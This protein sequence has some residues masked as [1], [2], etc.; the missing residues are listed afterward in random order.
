MAEYDRINWEN[1]PSKDTP[2][3][4]DNLNR[5]DEAIYTVVRELKR[6][7]EL[8][9][10]NADAAS[11]ANSAIATL[12]RMTDGSTT[13]DAE[14]ENGRITYNGVKHATIGDAIRAQINELKNELSEIN[15]V[16]E[17][18]IDE[19][20][21]RLTNAE[22]SLLNK[23]DD[24]NVEEGYLYMSADGEV[25]VGP[26]GPFS[27]GGGGGGDSQS[28]VVPTLVNTS[29]WL[30]KIISTDTSCEI[31]VN[32]SS[33][34]D[35]LSTGPG[36]L[37]V[38]VNDATKLSRTVEQGDLVIEMKD[39]L[40]A[41][42]NTVKI[43]ITNV[44]NN[45]KTVIFTI[46]VMALTLAANIDTSVP[47]EGAIPLA[48]IPTG[49]VSKIIH[50]EMDG[51][52]LPTMT[53]NVSGTQI[54]YTIPAQ[55]HGSHKLRV[56]FEAEIEGQTVLSN[57]LY[58]DLMC[59]E[60]GVNT[61]IIA[62]DY[63]TLTVP[64]YG[65]I[66]INYYVYN[67]A[68]ITA[69][70]LL[71]ADETT[72]STLT[73]D[74]S[75]QTWSY[76][77]LEIGNTVLS[78]ECGK[79]TK[80]WNITVTESDI[81][82]EAETEDLVLYLT[83]EGRSNSEETRS[84]WKF[85]DYAA[86]LTDFGWRIDG[87]QKDNE[88]DV[89]LR[90]TGDA[91]VT[92]PYKPFETDFKATGKTIEVEFAT[93]EVA[94]YSAT[95]LSCMADGIG[96]S[97]TPQTVTFKGA[98]TE[99]ST[100]YKDNEHLRVAITVSKQNEYRL[101][102]IYINGIISGAIQYASG[103]RFSQLSPVGISIGSD[104]SGVDIYNIRIYDN[105]LTD[106]QIVDNWIADTQNVDL[107]LE[108]FSRNQVYDEYGSVMPSTIPS[109]LPYMMIQTNEWPQ[110]KGDKRQATGS[111]TDKITPAKS[112]EFDGC[113]IDRQGTSSSVYYIPNIDMKF[114]NGFNQNGNNAETYALRNGSI[115]FNR[116]V[117]KADVASIESANN[118]VLVMFYN[119]TCPYKTPEMVK[120]SA[121]RWGIEGIP[122]VL[123]FYNTQTQVTR[124][125]GKYNFN[126]P[127]RA[128]GPYGYSGNDQSW[129]W[130]RNNSEN[131]KFQDDDFTSQ[132][133][134][135]LEQKYYPTWYDDFEARFPSDMFRDYAALKEF[136][137]WVKSTDRAAATSKT[138]SSPV[139]YRLDST[140]TLTAYGDD[141]T[142]T[143]VDETADGV[144]TGIKIVTFTADT[145]AYRLSKFRAEFSDYAE[146]ESAVFYYLFT[147]FFLMID[148]RA[149]NMFVGFHGSAISDSNRAMTRKAVFEPYD[150]DTAIGTNNSGVLMF[151]PSL[152]DTDTVS[153]VVVG[154]TDADVFNAQKSVIW[155]N[156]RDGFRPEITSMY[157]SL[158]TTTWS[159]QAISG[160]FTEHQSKWS[161]GIYNEDQRIKH[162]TP[163]TEP[164]TKDESTGQL[165]RTDRYLTMV[166]GSKAE[167]RKWWLRGRFRY[168]DSKTSTGDA[169][170][171]RITLR[172]F[173]GGT[174]T[175]TPAID[176]YVGV[177][178]GGGT[179]V[180]LK[181]TKANTPAE[182]VY[183]Q[184]A[185]EMET[186]IDSGD[187]ISDVGDLSIFYPNELDFSH[188]TIL[189]RLQIG[190]A[191]E[192][193][194]NSHLTTFD[195]QNCALL[196]YLDCR[197][198]PNLGITVNLEGSPRLKEAYFDN[199]AITGVDLVD[200]GALEILHLPGTIT[201]LGLFNLSKLKEFQCD[202]FANVTRLM[203]ANIDSSVVDAVALLRQIP[204]KSLVNIQGLAIEAEDA[205][206]ISALF[207]L[208]DTMTGVSRE[209][210]A[211]GEWIY[212]EYEK[213]QISGTIH[214]S[215]LTGAEIADFNSRYPYIHV[216]ADHTSSQLN[217]YNGSTFI[218]SITVLDGGNGVYDGSTPTKAQDAQ[219]TYSFSGWSR[220]DDNTVDADALI[221]VVADRNVYACFTG[222]LRKYTVTFAR[223]SA[224]G[225]GTLQTISNVTYGTVITAASSYTGSTPT[226]TKGNA[227][228]YPFKEWSP[229]SVRVT[230]NTTITAVFG[231]PI[232]APTAKTADG[233]WGVEWDYSQ[234]SPALTRKGLAASVVSVTPATSNS[235]VGDSP[236]D[237]VMPWAGMKRYNIIDGVIGPSE[238]EVGFNEA[239]YDT[240]V[241][242]P[243][244]YYTAYKDTT[245]QKWLWAISP[246][247]LNGYEKHPGSG[248]YI[249]RFHTSRDSN[250]VFSKSGA[251]PLVNTSQ[252]NFR[253]YSKNKG[254]DWYMLDLATWSALQMLYLIEY[255]NFD[256]QTVLGNGYNVGSLGEVGGT[257]GAQ[258]HTIKASEAHNQYRWVE[259]PFS[260]C[261]DWIDGF[262]G[263][264]S[265]VYVGVSNS[266]FDGTVSKL[267]QA[268]NLK[269]PSSGYIKGYGYSEETAWAFI[270]DTVGG[271]D[272]T[273]VSDYLYS[274][275]SQRP[276]S[277]GGYYYY[278]GAYYGLFC[279]GA[280]SSASVTNGYLGS[281]LIFL[282]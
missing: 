220:T 210:D 251:M 199:T 143:V 169:S 208:F 114:K 282:P 217:F 158:R 129:E 272:S 223:S 106:K 257:S 253:T 229:S 209:K 94:N 136:I 51:S 137:S 3:N 205:T 28:S 139:T 270:P 195:V 202:S 17:E 186:W 128:A 252:T 277:V 10:A 189:K 68:D 92:I 49:R 96:F 115:P 118:T 255:A 99:L 63:N 67:P 207:D 69:D 155:V 198:C 80:S 191:E 55:S 178:F 274:S 101:I 180:S 278:S 185:Q 57:E 226:T 8:V 4:A 194:S 54:T 206:E 14:L 271:S 140:T 227:T 235:T 102:L 279:F 170:A 6:V 41:G 34:E 13:G 52:E 123:F 16:T 262:I 244:F 254:T 215:S 192:G 71:K 132:S 91:R 76:R 37:T 181:R 211:S 83:A 138:L 228:D 15:A 93:R 122:I 9:Q 44:Y 168:W 111:Y 40:S 150:M 70:I 112:F 42:K 61:P 188:A 204:A 267:I 237:D 280:N 117:L 216:T 179:T 56:W 50:V 124:F 281:R 152:E 60:D 144:A 98:Q 147:E 197:N 72:V 27:G 162:L 30:S 165:I 250:G 187:L 116:F 243:E 212:H 160:R 224:D 82:A 157:R 48:L 43:R 35:G 259:D 183:S 24:A 59:K 239:E 240:V 261:L 73:V 46:N 21:T 214:T 29:G 33:L 264:R 247:K 184:S 1:L 248:R 249:G 241:Y 23:I 58:F 269:L 225:G 12:V 246:T 190:S 5:M 87:W 159:F 26:L 196:E 218:K 19:L 11:V 154:G 156:T 22:L 266:S 103:E 79:V 161:E 121:V 258:Y 130:Q 32:W 149:K 89:V 175:L 107:M 265:T 268:T 38:L 148:S 142:Y 201:A 245:N 45:S 135:E 276:A 153:D 74:R 177:Y 166:Q 232:S 7:R 213:A 75:M 275:S 176:L 113:E 78:I 236:F 234:S 126:L 145:P 256:S 104:D 151:P 100:P 172:L 25:K 231:S 171:N 88:G 85:G 221:N 242:I 62:S 134:D 273:F 127:K 193:Y 84:E 2:L 131:V 182:F 263:S 174:L 110:Y 64:Q 65:L 230:G 219:Y 200:G 173:S 18:N 97:I 95:V 146:V 141:T 222:T 167:Q 66:T 120:N 119:D 203:I 53:T 86:T 260:N 31:S 163:L 133:W 90:L 47:F 125:M 39:H 81:T 109:T 164:V 108:R 238:D 36:T 105:N 233:A 77:A 20:S